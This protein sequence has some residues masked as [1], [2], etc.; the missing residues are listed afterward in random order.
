MCAGKGT[1][2]RICG[3][4]ILSAGALLSLGAMTARAQTAAAPAVPAAAAAA[5]AAPTTA[6]SAGP[7]VTSGLDEKTGGVRLLINK[8]VTL[9][10]NRPYKRTARTSG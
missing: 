7:L 2:R 10:T 5:A 3:A 4:A 9:N 6:R 8:S 1:S